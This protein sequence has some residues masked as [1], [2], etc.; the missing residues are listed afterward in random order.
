MDSVI[1]EFKNQTQKIIE[2]LKEELK[3][4]RTGRANPAILE[5]IIVETY[6]GQTKLKL[7]ELSQIT[8]DDP[9]LLKVSPYDPSTIQDIEKAILRSPLGF[10]P[11]MQGTKIMV[12]V[13]ALSEE[14][15]LKLVKVINHKVEEKKTIIRNL[16]DDARKK[17]KKLLEEKIISEDQKYRLEKDIDSVTQNLMSAMQE[18][19]D[20]KEQDVMEV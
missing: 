15:R 9:T 18:I 3:S 14:Q 11:Q 16:R 19:K 7:M 12:R 8:V 17:I 6:G 1:N 13:P 5:S 2:H 4:I 10:N 20:R